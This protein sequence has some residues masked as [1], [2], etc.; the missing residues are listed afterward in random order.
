MNRSKVEKVNFY[1]DVLVK[2]MSM[3]VYLPK[4][5]NSL[6]PLPVLYFLHGRSGDENVMFEMDINTI[7]DRMIKNEEIKPMIIICPRIENSR[8]LNSSLICKEIS[9]TGDNSRIINLGMYEDY[10]MNEI[11]PLTD[12]TFNTIKNRKGR[13]IGGASAGGYAALHNT[14]RHQHMFS[15]VGG[16][17]PALELKLEEEDKAYYKDIGVWEKYDPIYIAKNNNISSHIDVYLD[18]GDKD[19]G[20]FYEGCS[21]L[22]KLLKE[23][24]INSQNHVFPGNHSAKYIQSNIEKYLKFYGC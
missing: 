3:L 16:H 13:Y 5:Y 23:K 12:K 2:Q 18:A 20:R 7:A 9:D 19:E 1:S 22:H 24:G 14:L 10:F 11:I 4:Y 8:G 15:K 17:M 6:T 21:I